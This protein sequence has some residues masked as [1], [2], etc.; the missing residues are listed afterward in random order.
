M[1]SKYPFGKSATVLL[2][3]VIAICAFVRGD[4]QLWCLVG[5]FSVWG[6]VTIVSLLLKHNKG[7]KLQMPRFMRKVVTPTTQEPA[8]SL[9]A[10]QLLLRHINSRITAYITS[11]FPG[12]TWEWACDNVE[13]IALEGGRGRISLFGAQNFNYVDVTL[14]H[15]A[16]IKCE[17]LNV[18]P[19]SA[20]SGEGQQTKAAVIPPAQSVDPEAW[21]SIQGKSVLTACIADLHSHGHSKL[22][23]KESGEICVSQD[24][25]EVVANT[26]KNFPSKSSW[27]SL[28]KVFEKAG[29]SASVAENAIGVS[30]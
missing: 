23:I 8:K 29:I 18:V 16:R 20:L 21:F 25:K 11:V 9:T 1:D 26:L 19:L 13:Q 15:M 7:K 2:V 3:A 5:A 14:D 28:V 30:W 10:E 17:M 6:I 4:A 22:C 12:A 24:G 27:Q